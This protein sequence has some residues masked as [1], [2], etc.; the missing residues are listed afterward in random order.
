[1]GTKCRIRF[2]HCYAPLVVMALMFLSGTGGQ[3]DQTRQR[4]MKLFEEAL[5]NSSKNLYALQ[6]IYFNPSSNK[7]PALVCLHVTVTVDKIKDPTTPDPSCIPAFANNVFSSTN[8]LQLRHD[9]I[10]TPHLSDL[11]NLPKTGSA[12]C[13]F[14][15]SFYSIMK[16]LASS[17]S[18]DNN[19]YD[20]NDAS[21]A[22]RSIS[23]H[24][25]GEL[26][27]MPCYKDAVYALRI[28]LVWVRK[29]QLYCNSILVT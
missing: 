28:V 18:S 14:E 5:V 7:S 15:T 19:D 9:E 11:L 27:D 25:D 17:S 1:M 8:T 4:L 22:D 3:Q 13:A 24:I 20:K 21:T 6:D 23:I 29:I 16:A 26:E 2:P 10:D 12:F